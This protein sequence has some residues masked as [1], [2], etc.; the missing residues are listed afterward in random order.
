[1]PMPDNPE[2]TPE[3][4]EAVKRRFDSA[5][6][7]L[8]STTGAS[9]RPAKVFFRGQEEDSPT[10]QQ[11][12][13]EE[14]SAPADVADPTELDPRI[15]DLPDNDLN[16]VRSEQ[17][18]AEAQEQR[19]IASMSESPVDAGVAEYRAKAL[20][21]QS[22]QVN[23]DFVPEGLPRP[24]AQF[25]AAT[26]KINAKAADARFLS[27]TAMWMR[28]QPPEVQAK[29]QQENPELSGTAEE[30]TERVD[31]KINESVQMFDSVQQW[32]QK[33]GNSA[34][35]DAPQSP[36]FQS[37]SGMTETRERQ[38]A[39]WAASDAEVDQMFAGEPQAPAMES[40]EAPT[41][42]EPPTPPTIDPV[43]E[44]EF[45][46]QPD[47]APDFV[48]FDKSQTPHAQKT[49]KRAEGRKK[50]EADLAARREA[51]RTGSPSP[52]T[53]VPPS[54]N[55]RMGFDE[56]EPIADGFPQAG[57]TRGGPLPGPSTAAGLPS[58][59]AIETAPESAEQFAQS[60]IVFAMRTTA[61]LAAAHAKIDALSDQLHSMVGDDE[62]PEGGSPWPS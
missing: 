60:L 33:S 22:E 49:A 35:P 10:E 6:D 9:A 48:P 15:F 52:T 46:N 59:A 31:S 2:R 17:L 55:A 51:K 43:A 53:D 36:G 19:S 27:E 1:M 54:V 12:P 29:I 7:L 34:S 37:P 40:A 57:M 23:K 26:N 3:E 58:S 13:S 16:R 42:D 62:F 18:A 47:T 11:P 25:Q 50:Q 44:A 8:Q 5:Q 61:A 24:E 41:P 20:E 4:I 30:I 45:G 56:F 21:F 38:D 14:P 32:R 39:T 28:E